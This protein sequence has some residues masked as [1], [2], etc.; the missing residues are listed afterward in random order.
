MKLYHGSNTCIEQIDLSYSKV[1]KDFGCGFYLSADKQQAAELA[2]RKTEQLGEGEPVVNEYDFDENVLHNGNLSVKRFEGYSKEWAE[3]VL[4]N[5]KNRTRISS[6]PY[7]VV[8]GPIANDT[9]GYQ[10]RRFM[11]GIISMEQFIEELKYMKG[12]SFQYFFGTEKAIKHLK[13]C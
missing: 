11:L 5:R 1:G 6:H 9:V 10:I 8:I 13:K 4:S 7:D 12:I 2:E 3:F